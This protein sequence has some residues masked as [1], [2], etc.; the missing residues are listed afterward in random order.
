MGL[1][2]LQKWLR[3]GDTT[4]PNVLLVHYRQLGLTHEQLILI[5]QL[6]ALIDGGDVFPDIEKIAQRMQLP[7][8]NVFNAIHDLIQKKYLSIETNSDKEGKAQDSYHLDLLWERLGALLEQEERNNRHQE[9]QLDEKELFNRFESEFG[10]PLSPME[11]QTIGMW[12]DDDHYGVELIEMALREAVLSQ[13]YNLKYVDRILLN[14][15]KKNIKT[16]A[17]AQQESKR[18]RMQTSNKPQHSSNNESQN[19]KP[20]VPLYNWLENQDQD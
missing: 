8:P 6:K 3:F 13:V 12:L 4:I 5:L 20:R 15:E 10:R 9:E 1:S 7:S 16:K 2:V 19:M 14:W 17:Q 18:R 11:M